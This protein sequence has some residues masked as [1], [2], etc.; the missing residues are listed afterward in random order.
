MIAGVC[1]GLARHFG[2]NLTLLRLVWLLMFLLAGV[3]GLLYV[4]LW[5]VTPNE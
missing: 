1:A 5:V 4:I 3:G 2:W